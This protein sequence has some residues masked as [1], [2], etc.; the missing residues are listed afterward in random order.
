L[1]L[2]LETDL[3][4]TASSSRELSIFLRDLYLRPKVF[5]SPP[6]PSL[7]SIIG[8]FPPLPLQEQH[9][10]PLPFPKI[11]S[12]TLEIA[13]KEGQLHPFPISSPQ[14]NSPLHIN[15]FLPPHNNHNIQINEDESEKRKR[16]TD[17]DMLCAIELVKTKQ[18]SAR[19]AATKCNV[20]R[21]TLWDRLSGRVVHGCDNRKRRRM[22]L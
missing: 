16:W 1:N 2:K 15:P 8:P 6:L 21:S 12:E 22:V 4:R 17:E 19:A 18:M 7:S 20:P 10:T 3:D 14:T 5:V 13:K 11:I 9:C